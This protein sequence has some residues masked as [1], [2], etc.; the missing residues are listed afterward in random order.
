MH[1]SFFVNKTQ[2]L[3]ELDEVARRY[4]SRPSAFMGL[5]AD[6]WEAYQLDL[7]TWTV[8]RWIDSKLAERNKK[9]EPV[10]RLQDLLSETS[11]TKKPANQFGALASTP[12]IKR[13][14]IPE[15]GIW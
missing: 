7:A 4:G 2:N 14:A 10:H 1:Y 13:M 12:G 3:W 8:G 6:S 9:G 11:E 15:S 5:P